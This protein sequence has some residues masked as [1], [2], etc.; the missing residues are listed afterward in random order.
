MK[1]AQIRATLLKDLYSM[2]KGEN[3]GYSIG[4]KT[5][6]DAI[7]RL[8]KGRIMIVGGASKVGKSYFALNILDSMIKQ[9]EPKRI[10]VLS[11]ELSEDD[12]LLR[13]ACMN[14]QVWENEVE[15]DVKQHIEWI[16]DI[17]EKIDRDLVGQSN[18]LE[19]VGKVFIPLSPFIAPPPFNE[20]RRFFIF[21][22]FVNKTDQCCLN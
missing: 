11:T 12:Y 10:L 16:K 21:S 4:I 6:D 3:L 19:I 15:R 17:T 14:N 22:E 18:E 5:I 9:P 1:I 8:R 7:G 20:T 13:Y 2:A